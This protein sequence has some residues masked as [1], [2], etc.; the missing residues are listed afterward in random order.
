MRVLGSV[1]F[2]FEN[3]TS[4]YREFTADARGE[5]SFSF[6]VDYRI[7]DDFPVDFRIGRVVDS[8]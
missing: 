5:Y 2:E 3:V 8:K 1:L 6:Y 7:D 4:I